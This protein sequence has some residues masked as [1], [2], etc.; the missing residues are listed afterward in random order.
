MY[1]SRRR[2]KKYFKWTSPKRKW[3][4]NHQSE[5]TPHYRV[6]RKR[7]VKVGYD[8]NRKRFIVRPKGDYIFFFGRYNKKRNRL[9]RE[10]K[11]GWRRGIMQLYPN[12]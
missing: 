8:H 3:Y 9:T 12:R 1:K 7:Q 6:Q 10:V 4:S 2:N 5:A 11:V